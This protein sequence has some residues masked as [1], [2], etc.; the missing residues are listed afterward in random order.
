MVPS[1]GGVVASYE[2]AAAQSHEMT[3]CADCGAFERTVWGAV[4]KDGAELAVYYAR[5]RWLICQRA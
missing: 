2:V 4:K 1:P 3:P 5:S